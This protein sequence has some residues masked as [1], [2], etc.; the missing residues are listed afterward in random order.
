LI[1][2]LRAILLEH[3]IVV[4]RRKAQLVRRFPEILAESDLSP[5]A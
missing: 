3:G 4:A 1:N 5:R 2:Q